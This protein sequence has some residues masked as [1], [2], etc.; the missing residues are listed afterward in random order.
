[1]LLR[2]LCNFV[3]NNIANHKQ[4]DSGKYYADDLEAIHK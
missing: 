2:I 3:L 1:M 4:M